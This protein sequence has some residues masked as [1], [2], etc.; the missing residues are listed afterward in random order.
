MKK[1]I[2]TCALMLASTYAIAG[3]GEYELIHDRFD[4]KYE[5]RWT[6]YDNIIGMYDQKIMFAKIF[7]MSYD[8]KS[9]SLQH[10]IYLTFIGEITADD[11][12]GCG[13]VKWLI[14]GK[15]FTGGRKSIHEDGDGSAFFTWLSTKDFARFANAKTI[16]YKVCG[17]ELV[18]DEYEMEGIKKVYAE[19]VKAHKGTAGF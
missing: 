11:Y 4:G 16:E 6:G 17:L 5:H 7:N 9:S 3:M 2:A 10:N 14:D 19:Y 13:D 8:G 15:P 12:A 1:F 18:F